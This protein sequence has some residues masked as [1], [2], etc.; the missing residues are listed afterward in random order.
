MPT[1]IPLPIDT[2]RASF[3]VTL[4]GADFTVRL[5]YHDRQD[6]YFL[7]L[8]D[9]DGTI[10][11]A[12]VKLVANW[13]VL[14]GVVNASRP[15]GMLVILPSTTDEGPTFTGLGRGFSLLYYTAAEVAAS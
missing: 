8:A 6:R 14:R 5:D 3:R 4:E 7:S 12:G 11:V 2:P 10:I 15:P 13:S 9:A 1:S